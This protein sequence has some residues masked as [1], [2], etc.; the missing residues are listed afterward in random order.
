MITYSIIIPHKNIPYLLRRCLDTIPKQEDIQ[1]IVV[2]DNSDPNQVDF[3]TFPGTGELYTEVYFTKVGGGA[4]Y[5]RNVGLKRAKGEWI[6]FVD[7]DDFLTENA[8]MLM[9]KYHNSDCDIIYFTNRS[10]YS[11]D[12]KRS[13]QREH[14]NPR[15]FNYLRAS[16]LVAEG[17]LKYGFPE[18]WGKMIRTS[19]IQGNDIYFEESIVDDDYR[20]SLDIG[21][22]AKKITAEKE[23]LCV[24]TYREHSL[25]SQKPSYQIVKTRVHIF[26][27]A[28]TF[29]KKNRLP[30]FRHHYSYT[31][32]WLLRFK[33]IWYVRICISLLKESHKNIVN[34]MDSFRIIPKMFKEK[35]K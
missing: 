2:D 14:N 17:Q 32:I 7:A 26:N 22:A 31:M 13:A 28:H 35:L 30:I 18:P 11:E 24:V 33:P 27:R 9:R 21:Y 6:I 29:F 16:S 3:S 25:S 5:A 20:F 23:S 1:I 12:I 15:V 19:L 8:L 4:G 10:V 34:I